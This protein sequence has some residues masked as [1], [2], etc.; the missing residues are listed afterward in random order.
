MNQ[1]LKDILKPT[2]GLAKT[3]S[4]TTPGAN[5]TKLWTAKRQLVTQWLSHLS[6]AP[7]CNGP[8]TDTMSGAMPLS[9][10]LALELRSRPMLRKALF[11]SVLAMR[12]ASDRQVGRG[13]NVCRC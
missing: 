4:P 3:R 1:T 11:L 7:I 12:S 2:Q 10:G 8:S 9:R 13:L 6:T 5:F